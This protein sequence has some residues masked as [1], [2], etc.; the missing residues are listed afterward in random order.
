MVFF[1]IAITAGLNHAA[2]LV[3]SP[4]PP[5]P[6]KEYFANKAAELEGVLSGTGL[7]GDASTVASGLALNYRQ[8][9]PVM[10]RVGAS[11]N[12]KFIRHAGTIGRY[13]GGLGNVGAA[14]VAINSNMDYNSGII[15][16][17]QHAWN[18]GS[19]LA[20]IAIGAQYGGLYGAAAGV[21]IQASQGIYQAA[22]YF[23]NDVVLPNTHPVNF[24]P[25]NIARGFGMMR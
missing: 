18:V 21:V 13:G 11:A 2:H 15:S 6:Y 17:S 14:F 10:D 25:S 1:F 24:S 8:S 5:N 3:T 22:N 12:L 4:K 19:S 16:G 7:M 23:W 20:P 9:L